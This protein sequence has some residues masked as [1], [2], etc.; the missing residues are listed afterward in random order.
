MQGMIADASG[1]QFRML[2]ASKGPAVRGPRAQ[3]DRAKY[4]Q[5]MQEALM[6]I[7]GLI[8]MDSTVV[9]IKIGESRG[10]RYGKLGIMVESDPQAVQ[11]VVLATGE[12]IL[13]SRVVVTT[14]TFLR[15]IIH[16]GSIRHKAGRISSRTYEDP[17]S[18]HPIV[19]GTGNPENAESS[20][21]EVMNESDSVAATSSSQLAQTFADLGFS[22]GR[23]KTGTPPRI[24]GMFD[25][26]YF[27]SS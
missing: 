25:F 12:E 21:G 22:V 19:G 1:I 11:G 26:A 3:M 15:G 4:K 18:R 20:F 24:D 9:D 23:L 14:G 5:C 16:I 8:V 27:H 13:C 17:G 7:E 2:N 10:Y 6:D